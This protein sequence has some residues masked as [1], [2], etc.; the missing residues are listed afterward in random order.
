MLIPIKLFIVL[1][2]ALFLIFYMCVLLIDIT[3]SEMGGRWSTCDDV[4][5]TCKSC[6]Y[7]EFDYTFDDW[8]C[9]NENSKHYE[10]YTACN[11]M[12]S[13]YEGKQS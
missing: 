12:C 4:I 13:K 10:N 2:P 3:L 6:K 9:E 7:H 11:D 1:V 8:V 5:K